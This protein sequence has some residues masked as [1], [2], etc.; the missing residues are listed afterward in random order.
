LKNKKSI[1]TVAIIL[2]M[3]LVMVL[4]GCDSKDDSKAEK[5]SAEDSQTVDADSSKSEDEGNAE[6]EDNYE[7]GTLTATSFESS[8]LN[9]KFVLPEGF[10]MATDDEIKQSNSAGADL[11]DLDKDTYELA[12]LITV[13]EMMASSPTGA[14]NVMVIEEKLQLANMTSE[15]Y[16]DVT[17]TTLKSVEAMKYEVEDDYKTVNIAGQDYLELT[18]K[19]DYNGVTIFQNYYSRKIDT[20]V[21]SIIL[22]YSEATLADKDAFLNAFSKLK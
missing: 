11:M 22:T 21:V 18:A 16:L 19:C 9:L 12:K 1:L 8:Y 6:S 3:S 2:S 4:S 7:K 14:S 10:V 17:A 15:Q 13:T 5:S 20:R